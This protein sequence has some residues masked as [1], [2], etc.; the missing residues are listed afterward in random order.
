[1]VREPSP[2]LPPNAFASSSP[3]ALSVCPRKF[4]TVPPQQIV[5]LNQ[6]AADGQQPGTDGVLFGHA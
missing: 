5:P 3:R 6:T 2:E 1:M 4:H